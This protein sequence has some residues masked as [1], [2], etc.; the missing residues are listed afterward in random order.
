MAVE[1]VD[2]AGL[3]EM[4][5]AERLKPVTAH[6]AEPA[7]SRGMSVDH[8][9]DPAIARQRRQQLFDVTYMLG[10]AIVAADFSRRGPARMQP[11]RRRDR[12]QADIAAA[13][14]KQTDGLD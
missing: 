7:Q 13:F 3:A 14:A 2:G 10:S 9:D 12:E 4:L 8:G 6:A 1:I 5:D 11:V